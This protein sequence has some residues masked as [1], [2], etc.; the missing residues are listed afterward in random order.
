MIEFKNA[1]EFI[2]TK[3]EN[4]PIRWANYGSFCLS[5]VPKDGLCLEF[6]VAT[7]QTAQEIISYLPDA[8]KLYGFDWFHG[9]REE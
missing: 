4:L 1:R 7:G 6:G 8:R 5:K 9:L 3:E 2:G